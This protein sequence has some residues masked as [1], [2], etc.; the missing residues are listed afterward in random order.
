MPLDP[1][2]EQPKLVANCSA[3]YRAMERQANAE[4]LWE[5]KIIS[6]AMSIGIAMGSYSRVVNTLRRLGCV[7]LI[8]QGSRGK[9]SIYRM[10]KPPTQEVWESSA[11]DRTED[12]TRPPSLDILSAQ[13]E[14]LK[15]QLGGINVVEALAELEQQVKDLRSEL[16]RLPGKTIG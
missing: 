11:P 15:R 12:L 6:L 2:I 4:G 5:G 7:E 10:V 1:A 9:P 8:E 3:L 16:R 13:V 14:D